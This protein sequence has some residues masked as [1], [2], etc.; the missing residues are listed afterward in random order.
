MIASGRVDEAAQFLGRDYFIDGKVVAGDKRGRLLR[1]PTANILS[2]NELIPNYGV[3]L[4][5]LKLGNRILN[6]I[7]NVGVRPTLFFL[8]KIRDEKKF[9][10]SEQLAK[11]IERD[12]EKAHIFFSQH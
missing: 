1:Y 4:S 7:T 10:D 8:K 11:Q 3:Y 6:G 12:I 5:K 2:E 9:A